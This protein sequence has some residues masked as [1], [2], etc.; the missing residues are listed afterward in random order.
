MNP[1]LTG[2]VVLVAA[3]SRGSNKATAMQLAAEGAKVMISSRNDG[4]LQVAA[5]IGDKSGADE[6]VC[7]VADVARSEDVQGLV[8]RT[9]ER[10]VGSTS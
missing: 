4:E 7:A 1:G 3:S 8:D 10:F 5:E 6:V 9:T 2:R